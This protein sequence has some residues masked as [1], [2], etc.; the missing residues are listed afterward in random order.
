MQSRL[1][2]LES[3]VIGMMNNKPLRNEPLPSSSVPFSV[4]VA[5]LTQ[6]VQS[7]NIQESSRHSKAGQSE[8]G[9]E[10]SPSDVKTAPGQVVLSMNETA[11][12]GATHWA[13]ILKDVNQSRLLVSLA[14]LLPLIG[15]TNNLAIDRRS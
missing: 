2:H 11:Y 7:V 15:L 6:E 9:A 8:L 14:C 12:V 10:Q 1:N 5:P 13:A 4:S 3:L